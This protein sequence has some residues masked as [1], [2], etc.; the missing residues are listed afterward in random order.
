MNVEKS[1]VKANSIY[2]IGEKLVTLIR[3]LRG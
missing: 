2:I 1:S 3:F